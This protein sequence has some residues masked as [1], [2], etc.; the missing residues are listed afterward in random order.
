MLR[1]VNLRPSSAV[2][3]LRWMDIF[4]Q[5]V[6]ND[7]FN[8]LLVRGSGLPV[9]QLRWPIDNDQFPGFQSGDNFNL[10]A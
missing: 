5:P 8:S 1:A 10:F 6:K 9:T 7:F 4:E 3:L 2:D